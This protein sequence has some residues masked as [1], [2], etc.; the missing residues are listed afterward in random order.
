[1]FILV[2]LKY[3]TIENQVVTRLNIDLC[4]LL[5]FPANYVAQIAKLHIGNVFYMTN[6]QREILLTSYLTS[7]QRVV[8]GF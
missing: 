7:A 6:V 8:L 4:L 2:T 5:N 3:L 1:M